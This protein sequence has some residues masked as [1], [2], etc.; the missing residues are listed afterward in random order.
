MTI[1]KV[2]DILIKVT[3]YFKGFLSVDLFVHQ[4]ILKFTD[5]QREEV[6]LNY[7]IQKLEIPKFERCFWCKMY[8][9][10]KSRNVGRCNCSL[11]IMFAKY[12]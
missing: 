3:F 5:S 12:I 4:S 8:S 6:I 2:G 9:D 11:R 10:S 7:L 1:N